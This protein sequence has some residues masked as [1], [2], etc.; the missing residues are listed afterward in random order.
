MG[1]FKTGI[2]ELKLLSFS[3]FLSFFFIPVFMFSQI[4][5]VIP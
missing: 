1:L 3:S 2:G 5:H 4:K